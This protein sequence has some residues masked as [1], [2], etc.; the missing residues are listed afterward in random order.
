MIKL[1]NLTKQFVQKKGQPLKAVDNVNLNVPEGE[2]CVLLG[3]SRLRQNHHV[4]DDQPADRA[5]QR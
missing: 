1:E 3:P 5:Q 2:M 4:K